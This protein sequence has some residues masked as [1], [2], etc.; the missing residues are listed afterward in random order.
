MKVMKCATLFLLIALLLSNCSP[1]LRGHDYKS[2]NLP[3]VSYKKDLRPRVV[4]HI[5]ISVIV[6]LMIGPVIAEEIHKPKRQ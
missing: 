4:K 6:G 2:G 1:K 3:G 5:W